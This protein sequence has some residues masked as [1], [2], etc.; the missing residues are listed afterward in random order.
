MKRLS[1][2]YG[3]YLA[4]RSYLEQNNF[5]LEELHLRF[6]NDLLPAADLEE[7]GH[8][9]AKFVSL[10]GSQFLAELLSD[11]ELETKHDT[12]LEKKV[13][14]KRPKLSREEKKKQKEQEKNRKEEGKKI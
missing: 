9:A 1:S 8:Q 10:E 13:F 7:L 14:E 4:L 12:A 11:E 2:L 5:T 3:L 6:L